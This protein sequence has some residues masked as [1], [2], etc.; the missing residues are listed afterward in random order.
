M[1]DCL[2]DGQ[3]GVSVSGSGYFRTGQT[4]VKVFLMNDFC[5]ITVMI[6][7]SV[8]SSVCVIFCSIIRFLKYEN[9][10][11]INPAII[12]GNSS[13]LRAC[14]CLTCELIKSG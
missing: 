8:I 13:H 12:G 14:T 3:K 6:A 10:L 5:T 9:E 4:P 2:I 1:I 11:L 7:F